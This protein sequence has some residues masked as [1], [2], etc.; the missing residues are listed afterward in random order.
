MRSSSGG[1][2]NAENGG[3][4]GHSSPSRDRLVYVMTQV[5]GHH[6]DV[7]VKNG[8]VISGIFHATNTDKDFGIVL[9]M[10]QPIKDS[11]VGGQGNATDVVRKPETMIIPARELVQVFRQGCNTWR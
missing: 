3:K 4:L 10:A 9:K 7:H 5:I 8:S 6:V 11:S 2:T 1:F